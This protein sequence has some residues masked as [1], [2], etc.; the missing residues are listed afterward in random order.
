MTLTA[1]AAADWITDKLLTEK[2]RI[3]WLGGLTCDSRDLAQPIIF[4]TQTVCQGTHRH[5]PIHGAWKACRVTWEMSRLQTEQSWKG[6]GETE[7]C[8][9]LPHRR[10]PAPSNACKLD[11]FLHL[12]SVGFYSNLS[13]KPPWLQLARTRSCSKRVLTGR[14]SPKQ[15]SGHISQTHCI[16]VW[17][18][19]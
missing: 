3:H 17:V 8:G 13:F 15:M 14:A 11:S 1:P 2:E 16:V 18:S 19:C 9:N 4:L 6:R 7:R 5:V 12:C 10:L